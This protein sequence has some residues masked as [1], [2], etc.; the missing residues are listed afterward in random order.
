M[1]FLCFCIFPGAVFVGACSITDAISDSAW[2]A[3]SGMYTLHSL[4][5]GNPTAVM[6]VEQHKIKLS[7]IFMAFPC[8]MTFTTLIVIPCSSLASCA[9]LVPLYKGS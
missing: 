7:K 1:D 5:G 6:H 3:A 8:L 4:Q 9:V 2:L